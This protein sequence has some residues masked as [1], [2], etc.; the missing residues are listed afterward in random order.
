M[1]KRIREALTKDEALALIDRSDVIVA[2]LAEVGYPVRV[3][4]RKGVTTIIKGAAVPPNVMAK[5]ILVA[6][7]PDT[8]ADKALDQ[9][10]DRR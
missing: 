7:I 10:P 2:A 9:I 4:R 1:R 8:V 5:A 6:G 3:E